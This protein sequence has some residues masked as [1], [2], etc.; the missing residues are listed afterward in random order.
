MKR[1]VSFV[2]APAFLVA[3]FAG[4]A[5]ESGEAA[6]ARS[7]S[8]SL[9]IVAEEAKSPCSSPV[10]PRFRDKGWCQWH[11][12]GKTV[13][14]DRRFLSGDWPDS[15]HGQ[16]YKEVPWSVKAM[17]CL[18]KS[19]V[20]CHFAAKCEPP[21]KHLLVYLT[22]IERAGPALRPGRKKGCRS[23]EITAGET[24]VKRTGAAGLARFDSLRVVENDFQGFGVRIF[25]AVIW[26][27]VQVVVVGS[28]QKVFQR[29]F[30]GHPFL[31]RQ[32]A[33]PVPEVRTEWRRDHRNGP[34][35]R[36]RRQIGNK[37]GC[38]TGKIEQK[39]T[40]VSPGRLII[41]TVRGS[42]THRVRY[43]SVF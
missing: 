19:D 17:V 3:R 20:C 28:I 39:E 2:T 22:G 27:N 18:T 1:P 10:G 4:A 31:R 14:P 7:F 43:D 5:V 21:P 13:E 41:P 15:V 23:G 26:G 16:E 29:L 12:R 6:L 34:C 11:C 9:W 25:R 33:I 8:R 32:T 36:S 40:S 37:G 42:D 35:Q 38:L 30:A 24:K